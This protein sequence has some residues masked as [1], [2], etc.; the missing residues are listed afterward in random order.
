MHA[1][2]ARNRARLVALTIIACIST[3]CGGGTT[4]TSPTDSVKFAGF[5]EQ[6]N[7]SRAPFLSMTVSSATSGEPI[8]ESG[9]DAQGDFAMI[10]PAQESS[11][12][13]DVVGVGSTQ[14]QRQQQGSGTLSAK[15]S[16]TEQG[17]ESR[18]QF[19]AQLTEQ[20]LC[21]DLSI[22]GD[23]LI[24]SGDSANAP[25]PVTISVAS[26]DLS[27]TGFEGDVVGTCVGTLSTLTSERAASDGTIT[28]DMSAA[29]KSG[30]NE[31]RI[32]ISHPL[33]DGL[34]STFTVR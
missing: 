12:V 26:Q 15:L 8:K 14:V 28:L 1:T 27:L 4:G 11:L 18:I 23:E 31:L 24:I 32:V 6:A 20:G 34:E 7:G 30:C 13:V 33:A 17:L 3:S 5:A 10:L 21:S 29:I 9:T 16:A 2:I 25:C 19:E 22:S